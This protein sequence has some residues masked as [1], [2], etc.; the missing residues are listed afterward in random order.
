MSGAARDQEDHREP[1]QGDD[2][3]DD[4][5][6]LHHRRQLR[7]QH[8][9]G[10][11]HGDDDQRQD[12]VGRDGVAQ[13][14]E[15]EHVVDVEG[16]YLGQR[17]DHQDSGGAHGPAA[18]PAD[19]RA[20]R[21]RDPGERGPA[22]RIGAVHVVEGRGDQEHRHE[23][24]EQHRGRLDTDPDDDDRQHRGQRVGRRRRGDPDDQAVPEADR[25]LL[26]AV[27]AG[28]RSLV[29]MRVVMLPVVMLGHVR[30]PLLLLVTLMPF[31]LPCHASSGSGRTAA[32]FSARRCCH[33][34]SSIIASVNRKIIDA[35]T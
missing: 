5:H 21:P 19:P 10:G 12:H 2:L 6:P 29:G 22:V 27:L 23:S 8:A 15:A 24:G 34:V 16:G 11:H 9:D 3:E 28:L 4:H 14:V 25:V 17:A 32:S 7:P 18:D 31:V 1:Q 33:T 13:A 30:V 26:Q 20:H 35:I